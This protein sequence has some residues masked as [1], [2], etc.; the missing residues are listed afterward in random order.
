MNTTMTRV[1]GIYER[2]LGLTMVMVPNESIIFLGPDPN[3]DPYTNN[4]VSA[5]LGQNQQV[6][7][8][9]IGTENYDYWS[10]L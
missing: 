10:C 9:N 7:D 8:D 4:N 6:C 2:D 3:S 5:M 1:N